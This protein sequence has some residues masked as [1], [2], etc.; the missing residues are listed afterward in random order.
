MRRRHELPWAV[1]L[2]FACVEEPASKEAGFLI[3][4]GAYL[5]EILRRAKGARLRMTKSL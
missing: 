5:A 1:E 4:D 2:S 3:Y